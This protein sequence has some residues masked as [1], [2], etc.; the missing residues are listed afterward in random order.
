VSALVHTGAREQA[1]T[2]ISA[3]SDLLRYA[4]DRSGG[5]HV[6]MGDEIEMLRRYLEIQRIRFADR[7]TYSI[8]MAPDAAGASVPVLL[9][10]P[11]AENAVKHGLVGARGAGR[12]EVR[13]A[14][15]GDRLR[16][17]IWNSGRLGPERGNGIGL[18]NVAA[19][20]RQLHGD[21]H[22]L[23]LREEADGVAAHVTL[24]WSETA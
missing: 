3:I 8:E 9:L 12:V 15:E 4:L 20:L 24:P 16:I 11:L 22:S 5:Q 14:R 13:V 10:Q 7:L 1:L 21:R 6:T 23:E 19:R 17:R 2:M 18:A